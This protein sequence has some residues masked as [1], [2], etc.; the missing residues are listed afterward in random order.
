[1]NKFPCAGIIVFNQNLDSTVIV[2]TENNNYGFPK[3][4]RNKGESL[5]DNAFRE[6][7]EETG[8]KKDLINIVDREYILEMSHS[9]N[10]AIAYFVGIINCKYEKFKFDHEELEQVYWCKNDEALKHL[11]PKRKIVFE[12]ALKKIIK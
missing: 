1:M 4:K 11:M 2:K 8:I 9:G 10:P 5:E 6:L 7:E 3:G 12:Q